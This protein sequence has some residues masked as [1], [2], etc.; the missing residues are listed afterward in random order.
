M[1]TTHPSAT[2]LVS[3]NIRALMGIQKKTITDLASELQ[4]ARQTAGLYTNGNQAM[5]SDQL[6]TT[7]HWLGVEVGELFRKDVYQLTPA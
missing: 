6:A 3:A 2:E 1:K 4:V 5:T 7:A